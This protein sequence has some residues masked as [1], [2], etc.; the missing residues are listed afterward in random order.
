MGDKEEWI[1]IW[2]PP[3]GDRKKV[4]RTEA[5]ARE[6]AAT[7][8]EASDWNPLLEHRVTTVVSEILPLAALEGYPEAHLDKT[9]EEGKV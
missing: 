9:S 4:F 7:D 6:F 1:I 3:S 8:E 5:E 2:F